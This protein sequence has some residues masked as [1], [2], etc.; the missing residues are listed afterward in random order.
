MSS[1]NNGLTF[2]EIFN[3]AVRNSRVNPSD[4]TNK[5]KRDKC[6]T[7]AMPQIP[8]T[9]QRAIPAN[10][11]QIKPIPPSVF[12]RGPIFTECKKNIVFNRRNNSQNNNINSET[13]VEQYV[14]L[15]RGFSR[16]GYRRST[17]ASQNLEIT[18]SNTKNLRPE[19]TNSNLL[20]LCPPILYPEP[21]PV[22]EPEPEPEFTFPPDGIYPPMLYPDAE[23][24][25]P[26]DGIY[27][28]ML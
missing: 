11:P 21:E 13:K 6:R 14:R 12:L 22:P 8:R 26:P 10:C 20:L 27:P 28:P 5:N 15:A 4:E 24:T 25:F 9:G 23:F 17:N 19:I 3:N 18:N 16:G 2:N 7:I 1:N